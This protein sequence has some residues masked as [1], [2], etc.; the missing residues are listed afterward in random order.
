VCHFIDFASFLAGAGPTDATALAAAGA[1][2]PREDDV[3]ATVAFAD[4]SIA[5]IVYAALGDPAMPKER[6]E[7]LGEAG[8]A[9]LDDFR[10][11]HLYRGGR[12]EVSRS[13]RDK[14][15]AGELAEF[16]QA[17]RDGRQP[18]PVE[19]M[20][21]VTRATFRIRDRLREAAGGSG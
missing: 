2:E 16:V 7:V 20:L 6:V 10:E 8:A 17:C 11:L 1:S 18:W 3:A 14:G 21:A 19:D 12:S 13:R 5:S 4:G 9:T 15:H